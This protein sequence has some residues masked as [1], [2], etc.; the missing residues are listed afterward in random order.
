MLFTF[1]VSS[2]SKSYVA[3]HPAENWLAA[4]EALLRSPAFREFSEALMPSTVGAPIESGDVFL[5]VPMD[6]LKNSWVMQGGKA[7]E[8]FTAI[9]IQTDEAGEVA[10]PW[11][12]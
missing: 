11:A 1:H 2:G 5:M 4:K 3:Q 7:G 9:I 8:Y 6:G 10:K 12:Q